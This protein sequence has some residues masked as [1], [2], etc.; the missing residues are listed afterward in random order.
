MRPLIY[1]KTAQALRWAI[2]PKV[3]R[4]ILTGCSKS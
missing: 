1:P 2:I 3:V 4:S